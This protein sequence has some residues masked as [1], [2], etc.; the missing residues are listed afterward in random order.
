MRDWAPMI[1]RSRPYRQD[2]VS[3]LGTDSPNESEIVSALQASGYLVE[4]EVA[5]VF[6]S[7][8]FSVRTSSAYEDQESGQSVSREIDV[9]ATNEQCCWN[10]Q[11]ALQV[12]AEFI[13]ECKNN[14]DPLVFLVRPIDAGDVHPVPEHA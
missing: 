5:A 2:G 3:I 9:L 11:D 12:M 7:L 14:R 13:C 1:L 4:Q 10:E 8:G 6:E